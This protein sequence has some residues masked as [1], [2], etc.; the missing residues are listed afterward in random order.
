M[1]LAGLAPLALKNHGYRVL[2]GGESVQGHLLDDELVINEI[3]PDPAS[4][5]LDSKDEFIE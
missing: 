1:K 4:P 3:F 5:Q 2:L